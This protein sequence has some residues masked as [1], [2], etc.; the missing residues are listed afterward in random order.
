M[1]LRPRGSGRR[2]RTGAGVLAA[3]ESDAGLLEG[4]REALRWPGQR[5]PWH[6]IETAEWDRDSQ[7]LHV[8]EVGEYGHLRRSW[9][10]R[11]PEP[12]RLLELVRERVTASVVL[13]RRAV[14]AG[15]RGVTVRGRRTPSGQLRWTVSYDE[16]LDP[17]DPAVALVSNEALAEARAEVGDFEGSPPSW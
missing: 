8:T 13:Q 1:R 7:T 14:V 3:A 16:G 10:F 11:I 15:R 17:A 4:T 12:G 6:E 9:S 2:P 5:L